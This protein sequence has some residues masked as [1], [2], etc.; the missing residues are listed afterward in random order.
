MVTNNIGSSNDR[1]IF[2]GDVVI[3][4]DLQ[5]QSLL[6]RGNHPLE[7]NRPFAIPWDAFRVHDAFG[8]SLP[9]TPLTDDLGLVGGTFGTG[10]PSIQTED[11]KAAGA[12]TSYARFTFQLPAEYDD[13]QTVTLRVRAGMLTT[14]AD[15]AAT[16]D[17][18]AYESDGEAGVDAADLVT[19]AAASINSTTLADFDF[20]IDGSSLVAGDLLDIRLTVTV[21]DAATATAVKAILGSIEMLVDIRG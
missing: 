3:N 19:T 18:E 5:P 21:N 10:T 2:A 12:T 6:D 4:G 15:M 14:I 11:L 13:G 20:V 17:V 1:T 7:S 16:L 8:T 9:G